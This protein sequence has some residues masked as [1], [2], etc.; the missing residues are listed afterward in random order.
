MFA[1]E[2]MK[3]HKSWALIH[4]YRTKKEGWMAGPI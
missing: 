3:E 4:I 2:E 1:K